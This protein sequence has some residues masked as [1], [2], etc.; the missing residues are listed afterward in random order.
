MR[1]FAFALGSC[2]T[3]DS[4]IV[5]SGD[6]R[7]ADGEPA[8]P[9]S[10]TLGRF[11]DAS[12]DVDDCLRFARGEGASGSTGRITAEDMGLRGLLAREG[13]AIDLYLPNSS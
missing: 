7:R 2:L 5:D 3:P 9:S 12:S 8:V 13:T 4:C 6:A 1:S 10:D 11:E